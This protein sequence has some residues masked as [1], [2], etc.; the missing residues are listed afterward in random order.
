M[1]GAAAHVDA[2]DG[3]PRVSDSR[4]PGTAHDEHDVRRV[5]VDVGGDT[6]RRQ[7]KDE[8]VLDDAA[9]LERRRFEVGG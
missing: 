7:R 6:P 2:H 8:R 1:T 3:P 5:A 9:K 4:R